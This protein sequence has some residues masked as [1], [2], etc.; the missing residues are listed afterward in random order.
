MPK[1][2]KITTSSSAQDAVNAM[3]N[4]PQL[5][6]KSGGEGQVW[7]VT[8][9]PTVKGSIPLSS[10]NRKN[11]EVALQALIDAR[12]TYHLSDQ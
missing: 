1:L 3:K 6:L 11:L 8:A 5:T 10:H 12:T 9:H 2:S 7:Y 4:C